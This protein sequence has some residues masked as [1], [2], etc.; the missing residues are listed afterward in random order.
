M[1]IQN[2]RASNV[3]QYRYVLLVRDIPRPQIVIPRKSK[4][5]MVMKISNIESFW[6]F[7][8]SYSLYKSTIGGAI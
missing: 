7:Q 4:I 1:N 6:R 3:K 5:L 2:E 8:K